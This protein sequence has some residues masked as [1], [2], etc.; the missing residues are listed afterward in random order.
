[1]YLS[2]RF[3][4]SCAVAI[5]LLLT[6]YVVPVFFVAGKTLVAV[7]AAA[8]AFDVWLL[9]KKKDGVEASRMCTPRFSNGDENPVRIAVENRYAWPVRVSVTDEIP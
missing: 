5:A 8:L 3:Y 7:V 2:R 4:V 6:G 9:W 1:M